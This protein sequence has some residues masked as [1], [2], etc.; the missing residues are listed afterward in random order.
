MLFS[1]HL[2]LVNN[3]ILG[4]EGVLIAFLGFRVIM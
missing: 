2:A 4:K 1:F 3:A